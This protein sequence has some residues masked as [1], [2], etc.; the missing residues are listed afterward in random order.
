MAT[1]KTAIGNYGLTKALKEGRVKLAGHTFEFIEV[2]PINRAMRRMVR[3][4]E[5]DICEMAS[6]TYLCA[7][8]LGKP[9]TAI[10]VF[11][12]RNFHHWAAFYNVN[13]GIKTPKDL[14]GRTVGVNRGYTVTTGVWVRGILN[15]EYGLDLDKVHWSASDDEHVTEFKA[16]PNVD[17][18]LRGKVIAD[19]LDSGEIP[20]AIGDIRSPSPNIRPL[21]PDA[22]NA[23]FDYFRKTGVYPVN[24]LVVVKNSVL[25]ANP[26]LA[27]ELYLAFKVAKA[28]YME[29]LTARRD[30]TP[31]DETA[32][33]T[34][35]VVG[36]DPFPFSVA[37][38]RKS[39]ETLSAYAAK[40]HV[41]PR[42]L[43]MED[44]FARETLYLE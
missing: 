33:A 19:L 21:I 36:G 40:Q 24:H 13:S 10:P 8:G 1:L 26:G 28:E 32:L 18:A 44:L 31:A 17:Y 23:G 6:T 7:K 35:G 29:R 43:S 37:A 4:L 38:N 34:A 41:I 20:A 11:L 42:L 2:D 12:T 5:F 14:E 16:P 3:D 15:A 39:L 27:R 25:D 30:L 22:R 9:V